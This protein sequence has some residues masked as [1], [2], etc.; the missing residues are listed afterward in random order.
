[1][2][3]IFPPL[4]Q[5]FFLVTVFLIWEPV[6]RVNYIAVALEKSDDTEM[7]EV[8]SG[9]DDEDYRIED[10]HPGSDK[11]NNS[12]HNE[13]IKVTTRNKDWNMFYGYTGISLSY[14]YVKEPPKDNTNS[15]WTGL[16]K[17]RPFFS[18]TWDT[19]LGNNWETRIS[20]KAFYDFAYRLKKR[21]TFSSEVLNELE[22]EAEIREFFLE[23]SL[24]ESLDLKLGSQILVW[25]AADSFRVVDVL[26]PTDN[27]EYG[28][29]EIE[30]VRI[31]I[32]MTRLDYYFGSYKL[33]AVAV[34]QIKFNKS[35]PPGSDYN[36]TT[37]EIK[38]I[39][40]ESNAENTEYGLALF[41][42]FSGWD[43]SFH[44]AQYF[45]DETYLLITEINFVPGVGLVPS[46]EY[47][48]SRLTMSGIAL[49]INLG[50]YIWKTEAANFWGKNFSNVKE[51]KFNSTEI[52]LGT[53]YSGWSDTTLIIESGVKHLNDFDRRLETEPDY[54][55]EDRIATTIN[56]IQ[57]YY[58]QTLHLEI[59]GIMVGEWGDDG[60]LNRASLEYDVMDDFSLKGG[61]MI[62]QSGQS[63]Y[64]QSLNDN[65]RIFF[66]ARYYF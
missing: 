19:E 13:K 20:A 56:F 47:R 32:P 66:E 43:A 37:T 40:P 9:F 27:R 33:Q 17:T 61:V 51:K 50:N 54:Q 41:G 1:M 8:L 36:P 5:T 23:G 46:L 29:T 24:F 22:K 16:T 26:N 57:D 3:N 18:L 31:P 34:H 4:I 60:G 45:D 12:Q 11:V 55:M 49:S 58:N 52:L 10:A 6:F 2:L 64:F 21:D 25:G 62:Y 14:S 35:A 38:E 7:E 63:L 44:W 42:T 65:D 15:D 30:D 59:Y 39:V 48:H 28:M 53:E